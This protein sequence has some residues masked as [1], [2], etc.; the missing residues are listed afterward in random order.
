VTIEQLF[1]SILNINEF[2]ITPRWDKIAIPSQVGQ[3]SINSQIS[4][5]YQE[6]FNIDKFIKIFT[7]TNY[8]MYNTYSVPFD[9]NNI[10]LCI[11]NGYYTEAN[12]KDFKLY[13]SDLITVTS[14]HPDFARMSTVTQKFITLLEN[15]LDIADCEN[16]SELFNKILQNSNYKFTIISRGG[17]EYLSIFYDKHQYYVIPKYQYINLL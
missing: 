12:V 16:S 5:T 9:Y 7:D 13:Y 4:L 15:M 6:V 2:F 8:L 11:T 14:T 1:P 3:A 17:V 10:L